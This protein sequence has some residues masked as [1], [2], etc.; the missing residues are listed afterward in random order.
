MRGGN[1]M[2]SR[3]LRKAEKRVRGEESGDFGGKRFQKRGKLQE[4]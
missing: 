1:L 2:V 3:G 4:N